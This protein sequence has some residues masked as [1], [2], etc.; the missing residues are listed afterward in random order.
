MIF[1]INLLKD[2]ARQQKRRS[3]LR[4]VLYVELSLFV[5][6][7]ILLGSYRLA[8]YYKLDVAQRTLTMLNEDVIFLSK[9]GATL[10][11]LTDIN[12]KY[13]GI[14]SS[15]SI[16]NELAKNRVVLSNK[17]EGLA[18]V[19][20]DNIWINRFD[21]VEE[22]IQ[23]PEKKTFKKKKS[24]S[25]SGFVLA[26]REEV[27]AIVR[28]FVED[29]ENEPLFARDIESIKISSISRPQAESLKNVMEFKIECQ[30]SNSKK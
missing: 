5:L 11:N 13:A 25:L 4:V 9:E 20:P 8:I 12:N 23:G 22:D 28:S 17:L 7:F 27:F 1:E 14:T 10:E 3:F 16:M 21:L 6:T 18:N 26:E 24:M 15:L 30:I 19:I 2:R 29:L